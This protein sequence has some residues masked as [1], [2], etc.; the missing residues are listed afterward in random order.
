MNDMTANALSP[1]TMLA[2]I[3]K[4]GA[5]HIK[6]ICLIAAPEGIEALH[7]AHPDVDIYIAAKDE[8]LNE[9]GYIVPGLGDAGDRIYGTK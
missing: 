4:H 1:E 3:K 5:R 8:R 2:Q 9:N 6:F 7:T